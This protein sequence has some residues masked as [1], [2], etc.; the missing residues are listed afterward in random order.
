MFPE[1]DLE[2]EIGVHSLLGQGV[3]QE[4][5][6]WGREEMEA[7]AGSIMKIVASRGP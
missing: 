2:T 4:T 3:T 1:A 7:R 5:A 6:E